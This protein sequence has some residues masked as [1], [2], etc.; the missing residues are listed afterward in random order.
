MIRKF[1]A[2]ARGYLRFA[3]WCMLAALAI[4]MIMSWAIRIMREL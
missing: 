3:V 4:F 1:M 2:V